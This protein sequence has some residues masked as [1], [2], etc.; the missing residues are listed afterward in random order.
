MD[1]DGTHNLVADGIY[2]I[3]AS[4]DT[5]S[6]LDEYMPCFNL[7]PKPGTYWYELLGQEDEVSTP[8]ASGD[9]VLTAETPLPAVIAMED[10]LE[11]TG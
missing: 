3:P 9:A 2:R 4:G 7:E 6:A 11:E 1:K 5:T 8:Q 10:F